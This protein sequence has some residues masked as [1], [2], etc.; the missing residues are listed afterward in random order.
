MF[1]LQ[2][3]PEWF[4][5]SPPG[6]FS[7]HFRVSLKI[8]AGFHQNRALMF[9]LVFIYFPYFLCFA[10]A[11]ATTHTQNRQG[12]MQKNDILDMTCCSFITKVS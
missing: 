9:L 12:A 4:E 10:K 3:R 1:Y 7:G 11:M 5:S 6:L 2:G 8:G